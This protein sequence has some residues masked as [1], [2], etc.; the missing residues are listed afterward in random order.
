[1][2]KVEIEASLESRSFLASAAP[3]TLNT[4]TSIATIATFVRVIGNLPAVGNNPAALRT[5]IL[6]RRE[7]KMQTEPL[8]RPSV[9][10]PRRGM[11]AAQ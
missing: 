9:R 4:S 11:L 3:P 2:D 6:F 8:V 1:M 10:E 7:A 5:P